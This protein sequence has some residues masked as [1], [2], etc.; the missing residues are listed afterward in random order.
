MSFKHVNVLDI[1]NCTKYPCIKYFC[2]RN[3]KSTLMV[4]VQ[5]FMIIIRKT[6]YDHECP[7]VQGGF[8][9]YLISPSLRAQRAPYLAPQELD[10]LHYPN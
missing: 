10:N 5:D 3:V 9:I 1:I 7:Q 6:Q 8:L 2:K 4:L